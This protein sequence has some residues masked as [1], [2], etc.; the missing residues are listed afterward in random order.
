MIIEQTSSKRLSNNEDLNILEPIDE[1]ED[2][3][4]NFSNLTLLTY[5]QDSGKRNYGHEQ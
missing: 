1:D 5:N 4:L 3:H 2:D